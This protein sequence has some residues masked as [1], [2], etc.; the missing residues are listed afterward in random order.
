MPG[1]G[2]PP[3]PGAARATRTSQT[4]SAE[5]RTCPGC[6]WANAASAERCE[7]CK[8]PLAPGASR[9]ARLRAVVC[10]HCGSEA[11]RQAGDHTCI[12]C[13]MDDRTPRSTLRSIGARTAVPARRF[14]LSLRVTLVL[15]IVLPTLVTGYIF[16]RGHGQAV[17]ADRMRQIRQALEIF[18]VENGGFPE[19]LEILD[20]RSMPVPAPMRLDGWG[21]PFQYIPRGRREFPTMDGLVLHA[22]CEVRSAGRN[23]TPGDGDDVVWT[24]KSGGS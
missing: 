8:I 2:R 1:G 15:L 3:D 19:R 20:R 4:P 14:R 24:G 6:G 12:D 10:P 18:D 22:S 23:G 17:T 9:P 11:V 13:G 21:R 7:F 16:V 5:S